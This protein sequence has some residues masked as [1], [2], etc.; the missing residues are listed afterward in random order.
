M[1]SRPADPGG[2]GRRLHEDRDARRPCGRGA[3]LPDRLHGLLLL[4][5]SGG[6]GP[7]LRR[8]R[9]RSRGTR[10]VLCAELRR[11]DG[12][13]PQPHRG[14][15]RSDGPG[16]RLRSAAR[17][18]AAVADRDAT[19]G[20]RPRRRRG[21][22]RHPAGRVRG[23]PLPPLAQPRERERRDVSGRAR[24][25]VFQPLAGRHL[26]PRVRQLPALERQPAPAV[27][28]DDRRRFGRRHPGR[29]RRAAGGLR[30]RGGTRLGAAAR[31][32]HLAAGVRRHAR[33]RVLRPGLLP[34]PLPGGLPLGARC[35]RGDR[36]LGGPLD[37]L[38]PADGGRRG[39]RVSRSRSRSPPW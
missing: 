22:L 28:H 10:G 29:A 23:D 5:G 11:D 25:G 13:Q 30:P 20:N 12:A 8:A 27:R 21:P 31:V 1:E 9:R 34:R 17:R 15:L 38:E 18:R 33:R 32:L 36:E 24:A 3:A 4:H 14:R 35:P 16:G 7:L 37:R 2:P 19:R 26:L 39:S 6:P